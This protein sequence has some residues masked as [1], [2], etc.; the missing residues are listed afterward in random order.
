LIS[1]GALALAGCDKLTNGQTP[2]PRRAGLWLQTFVRDGRTSGVAAI[3]PVRVCVDASSE[4]KNPIFSFQ[5]ALKRAQAHNCGA[6]VAS[7]GLTGVYSFSTTC[8]LP[9]GNGISSLKGTASGNFTTDFHLHL[10]TELKNPPPFDKVHSR[11]VTEIDGRWLGPCPLDMAPGDMLL[12]N[13]VKAVGGRIANPHEGK[14]LTRPGE[15]KP[16]TP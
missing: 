13:G 6:P 3:A 10:E 11:H 16:Q 14:P 1:A 2:P 4:A 7:R 9:G 12:A 15:G 5:T 8:P